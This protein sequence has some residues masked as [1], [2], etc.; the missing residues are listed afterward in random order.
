MRLAQDVQ[1]Q[2]DMAEVTRLVCSHGVGEHGVAS[3]GGGPVARGP[4]APSARA[5]DSAADV[6]DLTAAEDSEW[7]GGAVEESPPA[8]PPPPSAS[9][10]PQPQP[11]APAQPSDGAHRAKL[12]QPR[13]DRFAG[14]ITKL[15]PPQQP[16]P[17][18]VQRLLS[19][20]LAGGSS[21]AAPQHPQPEL[22][23]GGG[24]LDQGPP[25]QQGL[26][27][28]WRPKKRQMEHSVLALLQQAPQPQPS[29]GRMAPA[30]FQ[31]QPSAG[32]TW[33]QPSIGSCPQSTP[34]RDRSPSPLPHSVWPDA[35]QWPTRCVLLNFSKSYYLL[36][37]TVILNII[38]FELQ[39]P[40]LYGCL[41]LACSSCATRQQPHES[42][43]DLSASSSEAFVYKLLRPGAPQDYESQ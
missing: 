28:V 40:H 36:E 25:P 14:P 18:P 15:Q 7:P 29:P 1:L 34:R 32:N 12:W 2:V 26:S 3:P 24:Q 33:L 38:E 9:A 8:P 39:R 4:P 13:L 42:R 41:S 35:A 17:A 16:R 5:R 22:Q 37:S 6:V 10:S 43:G 21:G 23:P 30:F 20:L 19:E 11:P 27:N 31:A